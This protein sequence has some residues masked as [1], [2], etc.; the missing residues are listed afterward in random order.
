MEASSGLSESHGAQ[1]SSR[2]DAVSSAVPEH[3]QHQT[4]GQ[5][6][7]SKQSVQ[8]PVLHPHRCNDRIEDLVQAL[9]EGN[10]QKSVPSPARL[11]WRCMRS[12]PGEEPTEPF[13]F[14]SKKT[15]NDGTERNPS[16]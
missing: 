16:S 1:E 5:K 15:A 7:E 11:L 3:K 14:I 10:L 13:L 4:L 12:R 8:Q 2:S 9:F 6:Q